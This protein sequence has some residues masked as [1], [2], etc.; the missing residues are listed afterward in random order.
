[1]SHRRLARGVFPRALFA[2]A[3]VAALMNPRVGRA[4]DVEQRMLAPPF[5][6]GQSDATAQVRAM[7]KTNPDVHLEIIEG[8]DAAAWI[9]SFN[10]LPPISDY[11]AD[12]LWVISSPTW[13]DVVVGFF[14]DGTTCLSRQLPVA[15]FAAIQAHAREGAL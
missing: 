1:M 3:A 13:T 11:V 4:Q 2:L 6:I 7:T 15:M 8:D 10:A 9:A 14:H 5:C 12:T